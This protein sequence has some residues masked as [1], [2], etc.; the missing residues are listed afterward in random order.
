MSHKKVFFFSSYLKFLIDLN[1]FN[2]YLQL[3]YFFFTKF[4]ALQARLAFSK[5]YK[6]LH[7]LCMATL[8]NQFLTYGDPFVSRLFYFSLVSNSVTPWSI[9]L[10]EYIKGPQL[11]KNF[12]T[13]YGTRRFIT[14]FKRARYLSLS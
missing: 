7:S 11:V 4:T 10:P 12:P 14:A 2:C 6:L 8:S 1:L 13:F 9:N 3:S 5:R